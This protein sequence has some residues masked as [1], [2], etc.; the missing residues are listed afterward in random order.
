MFN[1]I[2]KF[3]LTLVCHI[4]RLVFTRIA[5]FL[6]ALQTSEKD[7]FLPFCR[8][9]G[10]LV[11][12]LFPYRKTDF[13]LIELLCFVGF[14]LFTSNLIVDK[15]IHFNVLTTDSQKAGLFTQSG[16]R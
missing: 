14:R 2:G 1:L 15:N 7:F 12:T 10:S 16:K 13:S 11:K 8:H 9:V 3:N 4:N 5:T 6:A